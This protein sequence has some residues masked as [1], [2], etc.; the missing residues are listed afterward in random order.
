[1]SVTNTLQGVVDQL[2]Q[3]IDDAQKTDNGNKSAGTRVRKT[4]QQAVNELKTLRKQVLAARAD[5]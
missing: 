3:A 5:G 4:A 2:S 1:M